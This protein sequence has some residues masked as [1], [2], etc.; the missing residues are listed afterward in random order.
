MRHKFFVVAIGGYIHRQVTQFRLKCTILTFRG[1]WPC[2]IPWFSWFYLSYCIAICIRN[3]PYVVNMRHK[4]FLVAIEGYIHRKEAHFRLK[5]TILAFRGLWPCVIPWFSWFY[6]SYC[7]AICIRKHPYVVNMRHKFFV[8]AIGVYIHR[9]ETHF[10][11]K[12]T[13]LAFRGLWACVIPWFS[14]WYLP[15]YIDIW[16][17]NNP[18]VVNMCHKF[19]TVGI[20][21][22]IHRKVP[23]FR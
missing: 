2:V 16:I 20:G 13:I 18:Y 3:N 14:W 5:P 8:V 22:Y 4:F 7:I 11:L 10:G 19:F 21:G 6:L 15:Y 1:L 23:H 9:Q 12:C 17:G